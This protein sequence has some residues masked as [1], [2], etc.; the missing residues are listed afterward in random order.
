VAGFNFADNYRMAGLNP[1]PDI[2]KLRQDPFE[3]LRKELTTEMAI[4]LVRLYF[5]LPLPDGT[6]WFRDAFGEADLSFS[7]HE[8]AREAAVLAGGLLSAGIEDGEMYCAL[9]TLTTSVSGLRSPQVSLPLVAQAGHALSVQAINDRQRTPSN[10]EQ[11]KLPPKSKL[12]A[13][14]ETLAGSNQWQELIK[15]VTD[16]SN[17]AVKNLANQTAW[18]TRPLAADVADLREEVAMLWW[19][20]GGWSRIL[21]RPFSELDLSIS[22]MMAGIDLA[23]LSRTSTGPAAAP[24]ILQRTIVAGRKIKAG[25]IHIKDAIEA[26]PDEAFE[27]LRL[28]DVVGRWDVF[29]VL[30]AFASVKASGKGTAWQPAFLRNAGIDPNFALSPFELALQVYRETQLLSEL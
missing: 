1:G 8:N 15:K 14:A 23:N 18:V 4:N 5:G 17:E 24:A 30:G 19:H 21:D 16:E 11:I 3:K 27:K 13:E 29:P 20:I 7:L 9:A 26:M 12:P 10:P 6:D 28:D 2:L 22:A 25:K